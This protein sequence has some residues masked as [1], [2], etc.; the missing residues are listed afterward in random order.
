[1]ITIPFHFRLLNAFSNLKN[2]FKGIIWVILGIL[3]DSIGIGKDS[4]RLRRV[5]KLADS[6]SMKI[7]MVAINYLEGILLFFVR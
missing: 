7:M 3:L 6:I 4:W 2:H 1:M 5:P